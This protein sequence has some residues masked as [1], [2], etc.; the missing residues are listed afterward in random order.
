MVYQYQRFVVT[1]IL[2]FGAV[3]LCTRSSAANASWPA[4]R[5]DN[6]RR[7]YSAQ[8]L[9]RPAL[10]MHV[11]R[12]TGARTHWH[13]RPNCRTLAAKASISWQ[14]I[15][16]PPFLAHSC[17]RTARSTSGRGRG[18]ACFRWRYGIDAPNIPWAGC[19]AQWDYVARKALA[20]ASP[21]LS[22]CQNQRG[23]LLRSALRSGA[24][25]VQRLLSASE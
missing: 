8:E 17:V 25:L 3:A 18:R 6:T 23:P 12:P 14:V 5:G 1:V 22:P 20:T 4:Y 10:P 2:A 24:R 15:L 21:D 13:L 19:H 16:L 11:G 7:G 9:L